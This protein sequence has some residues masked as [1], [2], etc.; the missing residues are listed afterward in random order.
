MMIYVG[1]NSMS[2][3]RWIIIRRFIGVVFICATSM[4]WAQTHSRTGTAAATFL[5]FGYGGVASAMG[6]A[7]VSMGSDL[8]SAYWNPAGLGYLEQN[9]IQIMRQ[10]WILDIHS[11]YIGG[12]YVHPMIGTFAVT[13]FQTSY[14]SEEVTTVSSPEGTGEMFN[15]SDFCFSVI[16]ARKLAEWFSFG[17]SAKYISSRI[18]KESATALAMDLGAVVNTRFF[19]WTGKPGDGLNIG[20]SISNYGTQMRFDGMD[21][22]QTVDI[23]PDENGNY[24]YNPARFE[25]TY[26]ELPLIARIGASVH[27]LIYGPHKVTVAVD[28]LHPNNNSEYVNAG[29]QYV[30]ALPAHGALYLRGGYKGLFM[31]ESEYGMTFGFGLKI[32]YLRNRAMQLDYAYRSMGILGYLQMYTLSFML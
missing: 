8:S 3:K 6:S 29:M 1:G 18:W 22:K 16:Y 20:M 28:F 14:G 31:D 4:G 25:T 10:P 17:A 19:S 26:W 9:Q 11:N 27:P 21:L 2:P 30:F 13:L 5:E 24:A 23:A 7:Y 12:A 15:G 32:N